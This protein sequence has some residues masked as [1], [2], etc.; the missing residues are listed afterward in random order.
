MLLSTSP[1]NGAS[2]MPVSV[3]KTGGLLQLDRPVGRVEE[4]FPARVALVGEP[5]IDH[6][7]ALRLHRLGN[8]MHVCLVRRAAALLDVALHTAADDVLPRAL[9]A[10]ALGHDVVERQLRRRVLLAAVLATVRIAR[11]DV[12]A[13]ELDVLPRE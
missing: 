12:A 13:V 3:R 6:R 1:R 7:R 5:D 2:P 9:A 4:L 8:Q 10:L 11:V